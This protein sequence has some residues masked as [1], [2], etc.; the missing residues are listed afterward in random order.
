M[1]LF[2]TT[3]IQD[4]SFL[5]IN[6]VGSNPNPP[7]RHRGHDREED[8]EKEKGDDELRLSPLVDKLGR[9]EEESE[10]DLRK[11]Y[12]RCLGHEEKKDVDDLS[13]K[14]SVPVISTYHPSLFLCLS[15]QLERVLGADVRLPR[16][17]FLFLPVSLGLPLLLLI[18]MTVSPFL[19]AI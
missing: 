11:F 12:K 15:R 19:H 14:L 16:S 4:N 7:R 17:P 6:Q 3:P 13:W 18:N 8:E 1:D 10:D 5:K 9:E 2:R